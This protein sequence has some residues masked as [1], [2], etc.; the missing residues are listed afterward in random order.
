MHECNVCDG[1]PVVSLRYARLLHVVHK[2]TD[3]LAALAP[4]RDFSAKDRALWLR[5]SSVSPST[6]QCR[7]CLPGQGPQWSSRRP[8]LADQPT[9]ELNWWLSWTMRGSRPEARF[10]P[11]RLCSTHVGQRV[12]LMRCLF[13]ALKPPARGLSAAARRP[14]PNVGRSK[15]DAA[16]VN[17]DIGA[18]DVRAGA[19]HQH[20][21]H[22]SHL[23]G[24]A[25]PPKRI[26]LGP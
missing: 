5:L 23:P 21:H 3:A 17:N 22:T 14:P 16:P 10:P 1:R 13:S 6:D 24:F 15:N 9:C 2:F 25:H 26:P 19:T 11:P 20:H 4:W 18:V 8:V 7:L 12:Q